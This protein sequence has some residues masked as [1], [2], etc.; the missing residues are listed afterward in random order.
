MSEEMMNHGHNG[1]GV[2]F[3]REDRYRFMLQN[4]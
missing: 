1:H 3:E 4:V 2:E